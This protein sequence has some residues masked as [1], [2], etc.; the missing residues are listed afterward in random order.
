[1]G[2]SSKSA[3]QRAIP[4]TKWLKGKLKKKKKIL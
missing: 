4:L 3:V 2:E 1:V